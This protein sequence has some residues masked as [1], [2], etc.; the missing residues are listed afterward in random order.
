MVAALANDTER[1]VFQGKLDGRTEQEIAEAVEAR[2]GGR[3]TKFIVREDWRAIRARLRRIFPEWSR[4]QT[5]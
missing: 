1:L 4:E 5:D 2:I 3:M